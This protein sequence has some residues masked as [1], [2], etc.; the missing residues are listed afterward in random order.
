MGF[1]PFSSESTTQ[2]TTTTQNA[3]FSE[4]GG[5]AISLN[6]TGGGKRSNVAPTV[7]ILDGG[8]VKAAIDANRYGLD[9]ALD[10]ANVSGQR[11][12]E[13]S[14]DAI[15]SAL[16]FSASAFSDAIHT[17]QDALRNVSANAA[18]SLAS[19]QQLATRN[20]ATESD[21]ISKLAG[22]ALLAIAALVIVPKVFAK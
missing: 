3:G 1:G 17:T 21:K 11:A 5:A 9:A 19:V 14:L 2:T 7:N 16:D 4:T 20:S 15:K 12:T 13:S 8:A 22:Y 6:L 10:F 18:D